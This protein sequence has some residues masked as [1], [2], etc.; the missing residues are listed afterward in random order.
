M[1]EMK[2]KKAFFQMVLTAII[3]FEIEGKSLGMY[4]R[5]MSKSEFQCAKIDPRG[6]FG[7]Y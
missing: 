3:V 6:A 7:P 1:A 5:M 4:Y 2:A